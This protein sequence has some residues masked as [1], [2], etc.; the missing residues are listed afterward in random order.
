MKIITSYFIPLLVGHVPL[1]R[2]GS[3]SGKSNEHRPELGEN[4]EAPQ[5]P[6]RGS[7]VLLLRKV[8]SRFVVVSGVRSSGEI[9]KKKKGEKK[10]GEEGS[11]GNEV[12]L[13]RRDSGSGID[14][15]V[16]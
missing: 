3:R 13:Y 14:K 4:L 12:S 10:K 16:G 5:T 6:V 9:K 11:Q 2:D 7:G 1:G 8:I 15:P